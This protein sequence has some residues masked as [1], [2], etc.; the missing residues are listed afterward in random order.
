M[1]VKRIEHRGERDIIA[2]TINQLDH[3]TLAQN[4][5]DSFVACIA[6]M[7]L[8][9]QFENEL[10]DRL[11]T[12]VREN[13]TR[14]ILQCNDDVSGQTRFARKTR[15]R[16]PFMAGPPMDGDDKNREFEQTPIEGGVEAQG[17]ANR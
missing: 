14:A 10:E 9:H 4:G 15:M 17:F 1:D 13:R 16:R 3:L 6:G 7:S 12:G 2:N 5:Q 11:L 8:G